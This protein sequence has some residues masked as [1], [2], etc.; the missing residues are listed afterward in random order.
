MTHRTLVLLAVLA[1][2]VAAL[3]AVAQDAQAPAGRF[4]LAPG[5]GSGFVRLDT[6]TGAVSHCA[7]DQGV[8]H[9]EPLDDPVAAERLKALSARVDRLSGAVDSL[10]SRVDRLA[11]EAAAATAAAPARSAAAPATPEAS[12]SAAPVPPAPAPEAAASSPAPAADRQ[13]ARKPEGL[14]ENAVYRLLEMI[15]TLKHGRADAT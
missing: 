13:A 7:Q 3:P 8:W 6:R 12:A 1:P 2:A 15:R 4:Q 14:V 5:A 9:C 10:A 11:A